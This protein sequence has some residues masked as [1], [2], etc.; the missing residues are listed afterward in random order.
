[1]KKE[2]SRRLKNSRIGSIITILL[3]AIL[4]FYMI[5]V[6]DEPGALPLFLLFAGTVWLIV[7]Q[8]QIKKIGKQ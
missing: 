3:G 4:I 8:L 1:M 5:K 2:V 6:E 7:T